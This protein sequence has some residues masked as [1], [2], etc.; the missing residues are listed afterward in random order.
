[1]FDDIPLSELRVVS[2]AVADRPDPPARLFVLPF[3]SAFTALDQN[4]N[5]PREMTV[6]LH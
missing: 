6:T 4:A 5:G 2:I 3:H 1:V